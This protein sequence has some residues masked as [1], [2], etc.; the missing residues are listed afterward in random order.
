M[1]NKMFDNYEVYSDFC[2]SNGSI[3]LL[4]PTSNK[5]IVMVVQSIERLAAEEHNDFP[6]VRA[7]LIQRTQPRT[8][9][10][11]NERGAL[12]KRI[13]KE[14]N[15]YA[16][17]GQVQRMLMMEDEVAELLYLLG[18][19]LHVDSEIDRRE[20]EPSITKEVRLGP[21]S[22]LV[23]HHTFLVQH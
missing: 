3:Q 13:Q 6:Q 7:P 10:E 2:M 19:L 11:F 18:F 9:E 4:E 12:T 17:S 8:M 1:T 21:L 20:D 22:S 14:W 5:L 16:E 15:Q 23:A